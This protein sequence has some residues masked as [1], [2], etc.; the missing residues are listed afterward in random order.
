MSPALSLRREKNGQVFFFSTFPHNFSK[1]K[2]VD[3]FVSS[4]FV[5]RVC[6]PVLTPKPA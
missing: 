6:Y 4:E 5:V 1:A 3:L 2:Y